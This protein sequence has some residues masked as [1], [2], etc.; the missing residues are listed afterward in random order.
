MTRK[1]CTVTGSIVDEFIETV[2]DEMQRQ[3]LTMTDL[4]K[5]AHCGRPY[6][7]RVLNREQSPSLEWAEKVAE[8]LGLAFNLEKCPDPS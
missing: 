6:L 1:Q 3:G 7:Y 2:V 5:L 4:A 8:A